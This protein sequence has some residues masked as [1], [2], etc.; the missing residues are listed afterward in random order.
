MPKASFV[1][2]A[3]PAPA[4]EVAAN[5]KMPKR[6]GG[7][8]LVMLPR[9]KT[10]LP[11]PPSAV[12]AGECATGLSS[13]MRPPPLRAAL[14]CQSTAVSSPSPIGGSANSRI[15]LARTPAVIGMAPKA[16]A[17]SP[18]VIGMAPKTGGDV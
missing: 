8:P 6:P 12:M 10:R 9:P 11:P 3:E 17:S 13:T 5:P 4:E 16:P 2:A 15:P 1:T 18:A 14:A 7:P